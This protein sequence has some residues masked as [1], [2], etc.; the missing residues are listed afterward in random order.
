MKHR[1]FLSVLLAFM[2]IANTLLVSVCAADNSTSTKIDT[3]Y[4]YPV[5]PEK[6]E[7]KNLKTH[8]EKVAACQI[9]EDILNSLTTEAL[10]ETVKNYPLAVDMYA[11]NSV[12]EGY[13]VLKEQFNG[14]KEL[15]SRIESSLLMKNR[16]MSLTENQETSFDS[17]FYNDLTQLMFQNETVPLITAGMAII[18]YAT[19]TTV[20]TPRG[21]SV[22]AIYGL[23]WNDQGTTQAKIDAADAQFLKTYT[24]ASKVG[25]NNPAYNCHSYAWYSQSSTNK[26]WINDPSSY[27]QDGSYIRSYT[28]AVGYKVLYGAPGQQPEHSAII[29][30]LT[31]NRIGKVRSKWGMCGLF[32]HWSSDCPYS[33][34]I[35]VYRAS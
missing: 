28:N 6:K 27:I 17:F 3:P 18:P 10:I 34:G 5:T 21:T 35:S 7:W 2:F 12:Q 8:E 23:T 22:P 15:S 30:T 4:I 1:K 19:S 31:E 25:A 16:T 33:S 24:S 20:K 32:D 29:Q 26:Y 14:I 11:Y 13:Q 9:P